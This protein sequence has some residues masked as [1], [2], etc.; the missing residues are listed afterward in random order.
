MVAGYHK[1]TFKRATSR[2]SMGH[3]VPDGIVVSIE[4]KMKESRISHKPLCMST[5]GTNSENEN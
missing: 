4:Y 3:N 2:G 1:N 5:S